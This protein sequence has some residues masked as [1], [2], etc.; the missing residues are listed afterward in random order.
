[1]KF[2]HLYLKKKKVYKKL[3]IVKF[4]VEVLIYSLLNRNIVFS[5]LFRYLQ[6]NLLV[7][8]QS[9]RNFCIESG[10]SRGLQKKN[11][12]S[13]IVLRE[14]ISKSFLCGFKKSSW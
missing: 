1:M 14:I 7:M 12:V 13:R 2:K 10:R 11:W 8:N 4:K 3:E 6:K 9:I 5:F